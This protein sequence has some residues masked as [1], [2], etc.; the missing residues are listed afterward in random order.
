L[1]SAVV[2]L[3]VRH[4]LGDFFR[5]KLALAAEMQHIRCN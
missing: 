1:V 3:V 4:G 5:G 2:P